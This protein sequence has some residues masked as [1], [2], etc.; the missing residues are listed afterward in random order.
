[1]EEKPGKV[2]PLH[3]IAR[4]KKQKE[5]EKIYRLILNRSSHLQK[6]EEKRDDSDNAS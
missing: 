6:R 5:D 2:I 3:E 1:M 4:R